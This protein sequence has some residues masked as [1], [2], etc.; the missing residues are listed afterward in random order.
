ML[1]SEVYKM[2]LKGTLEVREVGDIFEK[3]EVTFIKGKR[4]RIEYQAKE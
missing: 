3:N 4:A 2:K 1:S